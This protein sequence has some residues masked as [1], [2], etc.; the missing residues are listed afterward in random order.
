[1]PAKG[2]DQEPIERTYY[3]DP[4][5]G[6]RRLFSEE[7]LTRE[8]FETYFRKSLV[9]GEEWSPG[10]NA[11]CPF[12]NDDT[13]SLSINVETGQFKCFA[14]CTEGNK[15]VTFEMRLLDTDDVQEA[16]SSVAK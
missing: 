3:V 16:W 2:A 7:G 14:G 13:A 11:H 1:M 4:G 12:H 8:I 9:R 10:Q 5:T 15:L 6:A